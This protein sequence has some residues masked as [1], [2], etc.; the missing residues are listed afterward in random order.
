MIKKY[1]VPAAAVLCG[2][3]AT[4][5]RTRELAEAYDEKGLPI[6]GSF[7]TIALAV[8]VLLF[9]AA[10]V[11]LAYVI[12][13]GKS[14]DGFMRL[15]SGTP[16][17]TVPTVFFGA[18][19]SVCGALIAISNAGGTAGE[20]IFGFGSLAAGLAMLL[21]ELLIMGKK[22]E[23]ASALA[24]SVAAVYFTYAMAFTYSRYA[25]NPSIML[26]GWKCAA[27]GLAAIFFVYSAGYAFKKPAPKFTLVFGL[28]SI[29]LLILTA[30]ETEGVP[31]ALMH[32]F[33]A[34]LI[35]GRLGRLMGSLNK[36]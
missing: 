25:A 8:F 17:E 21:S 5:L 24:S 7:L 12:K 3:I 27:P 13:A 36:N 16:A 20:I 4:F 2:A 31:L 23:R 32:I 35:A 22:S 30:P 29:V 26:Y 6:A 11:I 34:L 15:F 19:A 9:I 33:T 14:G 28:L 18:A 10:S 1:A